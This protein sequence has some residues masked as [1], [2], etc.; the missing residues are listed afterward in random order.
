MTSPAA[1]IHHV[2][3][4]IAFGKQ[5]LSLF[6][7][8][9]ERG[10]RNAAGGAVF[11]RPSEYEKPVTVALCVTAINPL[12]A[13]S[14]HATSIWSRPVGIMASCVKCPKPAYLFCAGGVA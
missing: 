14:I 7:N 1:N 9:P 6:D 12:S 8:A 5:S 11:A 3:F 2:A 4:R 10:P 13:K